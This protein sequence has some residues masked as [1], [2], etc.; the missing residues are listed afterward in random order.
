MLKYSFVVPIYNDSYLAED[1]CLDF[2]KGF[3]N[4]L[5]QETIAQDV[6][7]IFVNDG[8]KDN[9]FVNLKALAA[10]FPFLRVVDL[11]R[12]F[13]QHI[14]LS[15]GYNLA[16]GEYVGMLNVDQQDPVSEIFVLLNYIQN[17]DYDIVY[18]MREFRKG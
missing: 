12:N 17:S 9:S 8:S 6:E 1:F 14:A 16:R 15:C 7:L 10:R 18:G 11:S 4:Y 5:H 3:Q 2:E 13:G